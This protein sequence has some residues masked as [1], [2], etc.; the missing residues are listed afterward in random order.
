MKN[1]ARKGG[2]VE[3]WFDA[4]QK[5]SEGKEDGSWGNMLLMLEMQGGG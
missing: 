4:E 5:G 2:S 3:I 1:A